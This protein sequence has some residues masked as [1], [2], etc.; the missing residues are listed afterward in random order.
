[1]RQRKPKLQ[2]D[3]QP[4]PT[5][6]APSKNSSDR[7]KENPAPSSSEGSKAARKAKK[8][9]TRAKSAA[10]AET[11]ADDSSAAEG[12]K[13]AE[14]K[15]APADEGL[16]Q[17]TQPLPSASRSKPQS[18]SSSAIISQPAPQPATSSNTAKKGSGR[19]SRLSDGKQV[20]HSRPEQLLDRTSGKGK[21]REPELGYEETDEETDETYYSSVGLFQCG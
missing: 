16:C 21:E 10:K 7:G 12:A 6:K 4:E 2:A 14:Q 1:M 8:D 5:R 20:Q 15:G 3:V 17:T 13:H 11:G 9:K 19:S 18:S